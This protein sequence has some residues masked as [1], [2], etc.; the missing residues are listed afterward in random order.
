MEHFRTGTP[1]V[2][3]VVFTL[4]IELTLDNRKNDQ[5]V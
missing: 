4:S 3:R 2:L 5:K 1:V